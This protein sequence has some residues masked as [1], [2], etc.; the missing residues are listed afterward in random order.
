[1]LF[2][3]RPCVFETNSSSTHTLNIGTED[4]YRAFCKGEAYV[5]DSYSTDFM[6]CLPARESQ[7]YT[8]DEVQEAIEK[9]AVIYKEK[10]ENDSW[11]HP[12]DI[13][14]LEDAYGEYE[15]DEAYDINQE[16]QDE[17]Y[18]LDIMTVDDFNKRYELEYYTQDF[19]TPSG[20]KMVAFGYYGYD[21]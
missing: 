7:I 20:D 1:M 13:H 10:H 8:R 14:M 16:R 4:E 11:Y 2:Q 6:N 12:I 19:T 18:C 21:G 5:I 17:R 3:I 9:Y 15:G